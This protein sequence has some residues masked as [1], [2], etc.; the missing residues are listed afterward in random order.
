MTVDG[1]RSLGA[2][3]G[4]MV[5][6][7]VIGS[8]HETFE[9]KDFRPRYERVHFLLSKF[10]LKDFEQD[11]SSCNVC[12]LC[13]LLKES[14]ASEQELLAFLRKIQ[15]LEVDGHWFILEFG[16]RDSILNQILNLIEEKAWNWNRF[17][18]KD[19]L[20]ILS[21]LFPTLALTHVLSVYCEPIDDQNVTL[22]EEIICVYH[23]ECLLRPVR[24][25]SYFEFLE[26]WQQSVPLGMQTKPSQLLTMSIKDMSSSPPSIWYFPEERLDSQPYERLV[27]LFLEKE[28]W[29]EDEINPFLSSLETSKV[30]INSILLRFTRSSLDPSGIKMFSLR[31]TL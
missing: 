19:C 20:E 10:P 4:E 21:S 5:Q 8:F 28:R 29:T 16:F 15:A 2:G 24:K 13:D 23:A 27:Q 31:K 26:V 14:Q 9:A 3:K 17:S 11:T 18:Q 6:A 7:Q 25:F 22:N 1:C 12:T 30:S